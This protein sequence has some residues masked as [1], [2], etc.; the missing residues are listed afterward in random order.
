MNFMKV[1]IKMSFW[2]AL[3]YLLFVVIDATHI[4]KVF[5]EN[6]NWSI[7][8]RYIL[9]MAVLGVLNLLI[10]S[11]FWKFLSRS[12]FT[13]LDYHM[14]SGV[15][16]Y[17]VYLVA[18]K[19]GYTKGLFYSP[20]LG[21]LMFGVMIFILLRR[22]YLH[23]S[24]MKLLRDKEKEPIIAPAA[25]LDKPL[26]KGDPD[27]FQREP[28]AVQI[29]KMICA[30]TCSDSMAIGLF[31]EWG[32][33]KTSILYMLGN[34][35]ETKTSCLVVRY[36][37]WFYKDR[38]NLIK[39][40]LSSIAKEIN[41]RNGAEE[42][43]IINSI[44][45]YSKKIS[46]L[47]IGEIPI[48]LKFLSEALLSD[49]NAMELKD[50][51]DRLL[52]K[53]N[54]RIVIL[55]DDVDRLNADEL[56]SVLQVVKLIGDFSNTTYILA[57]DEDRVA[58]VISKQFYNK[59]DISVGKDFLEK[60]IQVPLHLARPEGLKITH[61]FIR[62]IYNI[63][64]VSG[65]VL[66]EEEKHRLKD[67]WDN[68]ISQLDWTMRR[69]K[70]LINAVAIVI[71]LQ[72]GSVNIVD[73][74]YLEALHQLFPKVYS[75]VRSHKTFFLDIGKMSSTSNSL[76]AEAKEQFDV[77]LKEIS[78]SSE[79]TNIVK[80][81]LSALFPR[82][83][84]IWSST[85]TGFEHWEEDWLNLQRACASRYFESY[86][87]YTVPSGIVSD[88]IIS[89][90]LRDMTSK[91][92]DLIIQDFYEIDKGN[93]IENALE[94]LGILM[95][96]YDDLPSIK[97][98]I[99]NF[100]AQGKWSIEPNYYTSPWVQAMGCLRILLQRTPDHL[101]LELAKE[102]FSKAES[103]AFAADFFELLVLDKHSSNIDL[104]QDYELT[105]IANIICKAIQEELELDGGKRWLE[106]EKY[107]HDFRYV[108]F[109]ADKELVEANLNR[110]F[111]YDKALEKFLA[112]IADWGDI[113]IR[114]YKSI[115]K[116]YST[117]KIAQLIA[118]KY[119][120]PDGDLA[121]NPLY[122][123]LHW[124]LVMQFLYY[125]KDQSKVDTKDNN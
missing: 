38:H 86:F 60:I 109:C 36:N 118:E 51:I 20:Y 13:K 1:I 101:R 79:E 106:Y 16:G 68:S 88:S 125:H 120:F 84:N 93:K 124:R 70:R 46:E 19:K 104:L 33:G 15:I 123:D 52:R 35:L 55:I 4:V 78:L 3:V 94:T 65:I 9:L 63:L 54:Y 75:F 12:Y 87:L 23:R 61:Y 91:D 77:L 18:A 112:L 71:P 21:I 62:E 82:S 83:S 14:A 5:M 67:V 97:Y 99:A 43:D 100:L 103:V 119:E 117:E 44:A 73:V 31:G 56:F 81:L 49:Q 11:A 74:I 28:L 8:D 22:A 30:T 66:K 64:G 102:M 122:K 110:I 57:C 113:T 85:T 32:S 58:Q 96:R 69:I 80:Q 40:L 53:I 42:N 6:L 48:T 72:H 89:S 37:S 27:D 2:T 7:W 26:G 34:Y 10:S 24:E 41:K 114:E 25:L 92:M 107:P 39:E 17:I 45:A 116:I 29:G 111:Q 121:T 108:W 98:K 115:E 76:K 90:F 105:D 59:D 95:R 50:D 47:K